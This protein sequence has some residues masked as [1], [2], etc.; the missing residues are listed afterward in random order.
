MNSF[1]TNLS[2]SLFDVVSLLIGLVGV[3]LTWISLRR[4][5]RSKTLDW[6]QINI[7]ARY[8]S[9]EVKKSG[10]TPD[11]ILAPG[12]RSGIIAQD[13]ASFLDD[14]L[15]IIIG[16]VSKQSIFD[17][18]HDDKFVIVKTSEWSVYLPSCIKDLKDK[19]VLI[20]QDWVRSGEF[21]LLVKRELKNLGYKEENVKYCSILITLHV[22]FLM[23][24]SPSVYYPGSFLLL[25]LLDRLEFVFLY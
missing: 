10:F 11:F 24:H 15:P 3:F 21:L 7:G 4:E 1:W 12:P 20:A 25:S 14:D 13:I 2:F 8:I 19:K 6:F 16:Y 17:S 23:I 9:K 18:T 22:F 5:K